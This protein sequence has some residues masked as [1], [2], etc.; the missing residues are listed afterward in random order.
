MKRIQTLAL[1]AAAIVLLGSAAQAAEAPRAG[2]YVGLDNIVGMQTESDSKV[3]GA[4]DIVKY[5]AGWGVSGS[6][7]YAYGNGIRTE[8][9]VAYRRNQVD[10]IKGPGSASPYDGHIR[11]INFM[12]NVLYDFATGTRLTPYIGAGV[13]G[14][15]VNA[16]DMYTINGRTLD[17]ERFMFAYQGIA[18]VQLALDHN[19]S[20]TTDYRYVRTLDPKFKT[21]LGDKATTENASHNVLIG[22]R[23]QF[24]SEPAP[25]PEPPAPA[26][27]PAKAAPAPV[28]TPAPVAK[29]A[30]PAV[31]Q[32]YMVFFDFDKST[33]T[34]EAK[35]IIAAAAKD[36]KSGKYIRLVVTGHTDTKGTAK[37][38]QKLSER[39]AT[40]VAK[41]F[42][43]LGVPAPSVKK[44]G[45]GKSGLLVP[46]ADGVR[47]A[48]N[49]RAEIVFE[50]K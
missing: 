38:N 18:G 31:P 13:G 22:L 25:A 43:R 39:R 4:T 36:F 11:N 33:L 5:N 8:L 46:T 26:P 34:P 23:Y 19:W 29:P 20:F 24:G 40:S 27:V 14:A 41:E 15:L 6:G 12:G 16:E 10:S 32:S 42:E 7:G 37:Y 30:V 48:Q 47:E 2:W 17:S 50:T 35:R 49:R 28:P 9:E 3:G 45:A 44:L 21:N 1:G